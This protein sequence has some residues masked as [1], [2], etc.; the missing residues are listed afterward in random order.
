MLNPTGTARRPLAG[1]LCVAAILLVCCEKAAEEAPNGTGAAGTPAAGSTDPTDTAGPDK[2]ATGAE[3][4]PEHAYTVRGEIQ[5][6]PDPENPAKSLQI[7]HENIPE[8]VNRDGDVVGMAPMIMPFT[9]APGLDLSGLSIGDKVR[10]T[11]D[12]DWDGTPP[13]LL[14]EIAPLPPETELDFSRPGS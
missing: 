2:P 11:F 6:L 1:L 8:F 7:K 14:T 9:P 3:R 13:I 4:S 10:F 5:Q 12:V